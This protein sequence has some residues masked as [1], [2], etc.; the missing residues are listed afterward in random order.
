M[1]W[2]VCLQKELSLAAGLR[3]HREIP[4]FTGLQESVYQQTSQLFHANIS[5]AIAFTLS[6]L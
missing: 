4:L 1:I 5:Q 3:D 2:I 6:N